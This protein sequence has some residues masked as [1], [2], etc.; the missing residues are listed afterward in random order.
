MELAGATILVV[1]LGKSGVA[2]AELL[3]A[4]GA[5]V[6]LNDRREL[7]ALGAQVRA[8]ADRGARLSLG[9][10]D[11]ALFS[12]VDRIVVSPG[13]PRLPAL[14]AAERAGVPIISEI[15][16]AS[17]FIEGTLVGITGTNGKS[18]VTSLVGEM[19]R[20][21]GKPTFVGGNLGTPLIDVVGTEAA[22][23]GGY[24]VVE[25]SSFQLERVDRL[26][27]NAA[28]LLNVSA[29]HLDRY[30]SFEAYAEA[31]GHIFRNQTA[32]DAAVVPA[33]DTLCARLAGQGGG[34]LL[35]FGGDDGAVRIRAAALVDDALGLS[36]P[37]SDVGVRGRHNL[38]NACAAAL[39]A[40]EAGVPPGCID[41]ALRDFSGLPHRGQRVR[42]LD[43]VDYVDDSKATNVGA[44]V[45]AIEGLG[46]GDGQ[47]VLIAGGKDKGGSYGPLA[48]RMAARGRVAV[49]IGEAAPLISA[50]LHEAGVAVVQARDMVEAVERA[51]SGARR[52]DVVLLSPACS[53]FD[54]FRSYSDRGDA[55]QRAV[56]A[57][58]PKGGA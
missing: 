56:E 20:R 48:Q 35:T 47:V 16:L 22:G 44:A 51:R 33:G 30:D 29:D 10:H 41:G 24:T 11:P 18:T 34:R 32:E 50:A 53:S 38:D 39:L 46:G 54:M 43:G 55:F 42:S 19:C 17:A 7:E 58:E 12:G 3:L 49:L 26:R 27:V 52:G 8:L 40:R 4:R 2:A 28:A 37:V 23:R 57:L 45:A 9:D 31:K 13:V 6:I 25:L 21:T 5:S 14:D 15:E 36:L 1:G